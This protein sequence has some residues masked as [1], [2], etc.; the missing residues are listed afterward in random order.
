MIEVSGAVG[1]ALNIGVWLLWNVGVG[2]LGHRRALETFQRDRWW[3]RVREF[4]RDGRWYEQALRIKRWK[5]RLPELGALF[6]GGFAKRAVVRDPE[7]IARFVAET[8]RAEWVHWVALSLWPIFA[9]WNPPWAVAVMFVYAVIANVPCLL[10]Q[11]YNRIRLQRLVR[12]TQL[13]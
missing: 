8:R 5:D 6:Q 9:L 4:E 7:Y 10:V 12:R 11:R 3:A 2:Y 13:R 1:I